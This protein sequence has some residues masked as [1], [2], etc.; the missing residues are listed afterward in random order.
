MGEN[1]NKKKFKNYDQTKGN[2]TIQGEFYFWK[3]YIFSHTNLQEAQMPVMVFVEQA[4][5]TLAIL[6]GWLCRS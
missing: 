4:S 5:V 6:L 3:S 1:M 2:L